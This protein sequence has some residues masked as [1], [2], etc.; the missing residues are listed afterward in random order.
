L[1]NEARLGGR[2]G[3]CPLYQ[4][5]VERFLVVPDR[6]LSGDGDG[7]FQSRPDFSAG[8][9]SS[10]KK[11]AAPNLCYLFPAMLCSGCSLSESFPFG[12]YCKCLPLLC[13]TYVTSYGD[14]LST[15][16]SLK[17]QQVWAY[18]R[19]TKLTLPEL[20]IPLLLP[21]PAFSKP[22]LAEYENTQMFF[23]WGFWSSPNYL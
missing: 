22:V 14:P 16:R 21:G 6:S 18:S 12:T 9:L 2:S 1:V 23:L 15:D 19:P 10:V 11:G 20:L 13:H 3:L 4:S 17:L 5:G 7:F 8:C